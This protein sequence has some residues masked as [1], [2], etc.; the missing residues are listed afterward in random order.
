MAGKAINSS[1]LYSLGVTCLHLL[2]G[3]SPFELFDQ[4]E[5]E[6]CWRDYLV[7]N[8]VGN[9]LGTVLEKMVIL[10]IKKRYKSANDALT[11]LNNFKEILPKNVIKSEQKTINIVIHRPFALIYMFME[12]ELYINR[13][14]VCIL[15]NDQYITERIATDKNDL[16]IE[17]RHRKGIFRKLAN[18][19][20]EFADLA[21][22]A[23][24]INTELTIENIKN[25]ESI[26]ILC[27]PPTS[28]E[29]GEQIEKFKSK[30]KFYPYE[31][32]PNCITH[33][34]K[35]VNR[36]VREDSFDFSEIVA[37]SNMELKRLGWTSEQGRNYL[38]HTY[39]K[40]SRQLLSDEQLIEFLAYLEQQS[41][42]NP[43]DVKENSL[44][45]SEI[46]ARSN[47]ELK[48]LG[49]TSEQGRNYLLHTYGKRSRQL[50]SDEQLIEFLAYLEQQS[51]PN[52]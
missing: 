23:I 51:T 24:P 38:L 50:L 19:S 43:L 26:K 36:D 31:E 17:I 44:D 48:R 9:G 4:G 47:M 46:I 39:G 40:R 37:R 34:L 3:I 29:A 12:Y 16:I 14:Y 10:G 33:S 20:K 1:D 41:T 13:D 8:Y 6:W 7:N 15:K 42:P 49:W 11:A 45:F 21:V 35:L 18:V 28:Q 52:P 25:N 27:E 5:H 30:Q 32:L 2:T 22:R